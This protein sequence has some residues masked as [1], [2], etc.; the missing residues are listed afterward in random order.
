MSQA[1]A[2]KNAETLLIARELVFKYHQNQWRR[3]YPLPYDAHPY[4]VADRL[5][6]WGITE[7]HPYVI[8]CG[9]THDVIEDAG[10]RAV[11]AGEEIYNRLGP[12]YY[13][14][15]MELTFRFDKSKPSHKNL[16]KNE[17][18]A[19]FDKKSVEALVIKNADRLSN[20]EDFEPTADDP[21]ATRQPKYLR[22]AEPLFVATMNR[23]SE[24]EEAF[25]SN[26]YVKMAADI[27][28]VHSLL[29]VP[30]PAMV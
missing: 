9:L 12:L 10:E 15:D 24:I 27:L 2:P 16:Q 14:I 20:A 13:D 11:E 8:E 23:R 5:A 4:K 3:R 26:F 22:S 19:S 7:D 18:L 28:R 17:Y 30:C 1:D 25:G 6:K 21:D 29:G